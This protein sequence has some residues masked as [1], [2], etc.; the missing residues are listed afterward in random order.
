MAE[1]ITR[2]SALGHDAI[3]LVGDAP[4]YERFGFARRHTLAMR[5]PGPVEDARFLG[6]EL[7]PGAFASAKGLVRATGAA[8]LA[9]RRLAHQKPKLRRAA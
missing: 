4:Y 2:A 1:A 7:T 6:L 3:L 5:M 8:D 9:A